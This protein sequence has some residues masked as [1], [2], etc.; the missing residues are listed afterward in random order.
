VVRKGQWEVGDHCEDGKTGRPPLKKIMALAKTNPDSRNLALQ[1]LKNRYRI[2]LTRGIKGTHVFCEDAETARF[3]QN[4]VLAPAP[5]T[6]Q[7]AQN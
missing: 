5:L 1:L 4:L 6:R 7:R 2:F 3:L